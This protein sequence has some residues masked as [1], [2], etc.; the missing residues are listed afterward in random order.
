MKAMRIGWRTLL[1]C[2]VLTLAQC[3]PKYPFEGTW[4]GT[5]S[6]EA[7][8]GADPVVVG[9]LKRVR[10]VLKVD[11]TFELFD[12]GIPSTG[13]WVA[14]GDEA[15]LLV[16]QAMERRFRDDSERYSLKANDDGSVTFQSH[17]PAVVLK[18]E[19]QPAP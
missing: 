5:R 7:Q 9:N 19:S 10:L 1:F 18:R 12:R 6:L 13:T 4:S 15:D 16:R 17:G 2:A 14:S 8:P 3:G 11:G